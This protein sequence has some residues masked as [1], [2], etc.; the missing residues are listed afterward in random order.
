ME[1][2]LNARVRFKLTPLGKNIIEKGDKY[3]SY[4]YLKPDENGWY[5]TQL[6]DFMNIFGRHFHIGMNQ[7]TESNMIVIV[8]DK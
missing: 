6:W 2:S 5:E 7:W 8:E 4:G 1:V 3:G